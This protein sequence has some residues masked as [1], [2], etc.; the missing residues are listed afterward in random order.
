MNLTVL[1]MV[2]LKSPDDPAAKWSNAL[3]SWPW[4]QVCGF[5]MEPQR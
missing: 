2:T 4:S 1:L 5:P 3:L